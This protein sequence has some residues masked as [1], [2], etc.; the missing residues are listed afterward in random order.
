MDSYSIRVYQRSNHVSTD[1]HRLRLA[2]EGNPIKYAI[3]S[4]G[5][6]MSIS[7][8]YKGSEALAF[9]CSYQTFHISFTEVDI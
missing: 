5:H 2:A 4:D 9:L 3:F 8:A 1:H 6:G 7:E